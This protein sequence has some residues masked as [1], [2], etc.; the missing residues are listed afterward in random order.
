[1]IL[2]KVVL[3][4]LFVI[5]FSLFSS[6]SEYKIIGK[7]G[8]EIITNIDLENQIKY[9][10]LINS[11]LKKLSK[12]DLIQISKNSLIKEIIKQ[13]ET[14][15]LINVKNISTIKKKLIEQNY[16]NLG[17][18]DKTEYVLFLEKEGLELNKIQN[19][20]VTE[21]LWN[22]LIYEKFKDRLKIDKKKIREKVKDFGKQKKEKYE[23]NLS[24]ILFDF[25]EDYDEI[26]KFIKEYGFASAATKYS[27]S[28]TSSNGGEIGWVNVNNLTNELQKTIL[29]VEINQH[30]E[31]L[32]IPNG[33]LI[34]MINSKRK[35]KN[36]F[37][38]EKETKK[39]ILFEKERQL[40]IFSVN[41]YKKLKQN[42]IIYEY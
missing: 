25:N 32:K 30:T 6:S 11:N 27:I 26:T 10:L 22:S 38:L 2:R 21:Q 1:M 29:N 18:K 12:L 13:K 24:E 16:K 14:D 40:N 28:D 36:L 20:L 35:L 37:D 8:N 41:Y 17:F 3:S 31:P 7:V 39:Q 15:K 19:K 23:V 4:S 34:L 42:T 9:L 33:Y 5:F